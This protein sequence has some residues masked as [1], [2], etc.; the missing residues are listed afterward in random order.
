MKYLLPVLLALSGSNAIAQEITTEILPKY[1]PKQEVG[2]I[3][4]YGA[5]EDNADNIT[6]IG[7]DYKRFKT[8]HLGYR[9]IA[10]YGSY[11]FK[12]A[13]SKVF[14]KPDTFTQ[15]TEQIHAD[16]AVLGAG[17]EAQRHFYKNIYLFAALEVRAGYGTGYI[18]TLVDKTFPVGENYAVSG[19]NRR[20]QSGDLKMFYA[21]F[22]P[23]IGAKIQRSKIAAG[24]ELLPIHFSIRNTN[25]YGKY[26]LFAA[27]FNMLDFSTRIFVNYLF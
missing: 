27:D 26:S 19:T 7:I 1:K 11:D 2:L 5:G 12:D 15:Q 4:Q 9:V 24:V 8:E 6:L 16:M 14:I 23:T 21:S 10:A 3:Q 25:Y 20:G 13:F 22:N 17:L 18:D